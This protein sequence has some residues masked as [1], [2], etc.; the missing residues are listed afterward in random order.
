MASRQWYCERVLAPIQ[1]R[2]QPHRKCLGPN[3]ERTQRNAPQPGTH[4][5]A[6]YS[7]WN[8]VEYSI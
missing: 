7:V 1:P 3:A 5:E 4:E 8:N 6:L 2:I